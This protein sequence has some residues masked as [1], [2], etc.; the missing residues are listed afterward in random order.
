[1]SLLLTTIACSVFAAAPAITVDEGQAI[2]TTRS[3]GNAFVDQ[4]ATSP[5]DVVDEYWT[6]AEGSVLT[7]T[8]FW[9][10][11]GPYEMSITTN[12]L[13][14]GAT[15]PPA[16]GQF[17]QIYSTFAWI[18][19]YCQ[20]RPEP[21]DFTIQFWNTMPPV[22]VAKS[23]TNEHITVNNVNRLPAFTTTPPEVKQLAVG[24]NWQETIAATD[25]DMTECGDDALTMIYSS[26]PSVF[27]MHFEDQGNGNAVFDWTPTENELGTYTITFEAHDQYGGTCTTD[28]IVEVTEASCCVGRVGDA[29]GSNEPTDEIT[30]GDIML[31][32]D[33]KFISGDCSKLACLPEADVNQDGG[34]NPTCEDHVTLGDI[35]TLVDFLFI[36]GP[37]NASLPECL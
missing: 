30:L 1:V 9:G 16:N 28:V 10:P 20:S 36:T 5:N 33:V 17:Y 2:S 13:P 8:K 23:T 22:W 32:V 21:Y 7:F 14:Q 37:E 3:K 27:G 19:D 24:A 29:N 12:T 11:F 26:V 35:M 4:S 6:V 25:L 34:A 18:P 15:M 31:L